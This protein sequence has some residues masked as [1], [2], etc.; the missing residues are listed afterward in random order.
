MSKTSPFINRVIG[1]QSNLM[2]FAI[3]LTSDRDRASDL[4]QDTTLKALDSEDKFAENVN[5]KG[6]LF[7]IMRNI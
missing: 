6:W 1:C 7:T 3:K 5:L 2:S 4:V